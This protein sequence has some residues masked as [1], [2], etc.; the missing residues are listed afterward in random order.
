MPNELVKA[1][2][3]IHG[4]ERREMLRQPLL[5]LAVRPFGLVQIDSVMDVW[6]GGREGARL[7]KR[8]QNL[9]CLSAALLV[10]SEV[11]PDTL[12]SF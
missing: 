10:D 6:Y 1:Q 3:E 7:R 11:D 5:P 2:A 8:S 4:F 12:K 9:F